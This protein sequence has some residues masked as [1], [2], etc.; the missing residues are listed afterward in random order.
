MPVYEVNHGQE[1]RI[2]KAGAKSTAIN[3]VI[4]DTITAKALSPDELADMIEKGMKIETAVVDT[5]AEQA[6]A[7]TEADTAKAA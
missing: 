4:R 5:P 1:T 6:E 2:V 3:H 7:V